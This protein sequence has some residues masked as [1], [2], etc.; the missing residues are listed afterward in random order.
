MKID[1]EHSLKQVSDKLKYDY[2][3]GGMRFY[4]GAGEET[5][6]ALFSP[7]GPI[8]MLLP[9]SLAGT[10]AALLVSKPS[11]KKKIKELEGNAHKANSAGNTT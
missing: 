1:F 2:L 10:A 11:D 8:G 9:T 3:K 4:I 6:A 5:K 7:T